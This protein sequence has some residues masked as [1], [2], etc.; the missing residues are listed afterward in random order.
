MIIMNKQSHKNEIIVVGS[1]GMGRELVG[2]LHSEGYRIK[3]FLDDNIQDDR[4]NQYPILGSP[5][6]WIPSTNER[7]LVALGDARWRRYYVD[8]LT[9]KQAKFATFISNRAYIGSNVC[10]GEGLI[11]APTAVITS[12]STIDRHCI[13]NVHTS[14]SH[15]CKGND[16]VT[17]SPGS[18]V[19]GR[20]FLD[21][22][23][24]LGVNAG[25]IPDVK[26]A[27]GIIIG[28]GAVVTKS[29]A[30]TNKTLAGIPAKVI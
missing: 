6:S 13:L 18:R 5:N 12:D 8:L 21:D 19:P 3:G 22:D 14:I 1:R 29:F 10:V 16:F 25:L 30:E 26:I 24:F 27:K 11:I 7:F 17:F 28:A 2:Y 23:V 4:K 15:D 20:C 9:A